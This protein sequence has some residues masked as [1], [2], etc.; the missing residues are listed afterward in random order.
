MAIR[1]AAGYLSR[2]LFIW[3]FNLENFQEKKKVNVAGIH[4]GVSGLLAQQILTT[5]PPG[6]RCRTPFKPHLYRRNLRVPALS[7]ALALIL[8]IHGASRQVALPSWSQQAGRPS[9]LTFVEPTDKVA[10]AS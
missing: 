6:R 3:Q 2:K 5:T 10:L 4:P 9:L 1:P 8:C 7:L